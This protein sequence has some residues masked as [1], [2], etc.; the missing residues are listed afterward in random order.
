MELGHYHYET[1]IKAGIVLCMLLVALMCDYLRRKNEQLR[2]KMLELTMLSEE[3][4]RREQALLGAPTAVLS[5]SHSHRSPIAST[6]TNHQQIQVQP[7]TKREVLAAAVSI[8][9]NQA[10][11]DEAELPSRPDLEPGRSARKTHRRGGRILP[12][13]AA[14]IERG[15]QMAENP[16]AIGKKVRPSASDCIAIDLP[17]AKKPVANIA[18]IAST[19]A[20]AFNSAATSPSA[21]AKMLLENHFAKKQLDLQHAEQVDLIA[22]GTPTGDLGASGIQSAHTKPVAKKNWGALLSKT[23]VKQP[24]IESNAPDSG[25]LDAIVAA[26][27]E[28]RPA[29]SAVPAGYHDGFVLKQLLQS[30]QPLSGLVVSIGVT[31]EINPAVSDLMRSLLGPIDF[32]CQSGPDEFLLIYPNERGAAAQRKLSSIAQQLWSFQLNSLGQYSIVFTWGGVEARS[33]AV[34]IAIDSANDRMQE[35]KR[36]R[37]AVAS[38]LPKVSAA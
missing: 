2:E 35:T 10:R 5:L 26:T 24:S 1:L 4:S 22:V 11:N 20:L 13:C 25:L 27:T 36:G 15:I 34:E 30:H 33:E 23:N 37:R 12:S 9:N 19:Q 29:D 14:A 6:Q 38:T 31:G 17:A 16:K 18:Q 21:V 3:A 32:G 8:R 7:K 28:S